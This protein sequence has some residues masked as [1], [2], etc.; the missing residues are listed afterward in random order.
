MRHGAD[1]PTVGLDDRAQIAR[2]IH[3]VGLGGMEGLEQ[4]ARL[5]FAQA[6]T[7]VG[8]LDLDLLAVQARGQRDALLAPQPV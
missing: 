8:H 6:R 4:A 1:A 2:P 5:E 7:A 3:A